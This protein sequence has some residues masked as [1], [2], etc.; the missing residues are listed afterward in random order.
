MGKYLAK[1]QIASPCSASWDEMR[2]DDRVRFCDHCQKNV[3]NISAMTEREAERLIEATEGNLCARLFRRA[4][5][6]IL[7]EDCPVGLAAARKRVARAAAVVA[8]SILSFASV[9]MAQVQQEI[10]PSEQAGATNSATGAVSGEVRDP[11]GSFIRGAIVTC[12]N[13]KSGKTSRT[14]TGEHGEFE[15]SSLPIGEYKVEIEQ[16][17]FQTC[18]N[19]VTVSQLR[20]AKIDTTLNV[21]TVGGAVSVIEPV[22]SRTKSGLK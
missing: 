4:D 7:T 1:L 12:K 15:F 6:T 5:G 3:F 14:I 10:T 11:L 21:G 18:A 19:Q 20:R 2:G 9:A 8:S 13:L 17:G 16:P 22:P